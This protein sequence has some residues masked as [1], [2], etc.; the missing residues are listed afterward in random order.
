MSHGGVKDF[1]LISKV[2]TPW[3]R[4][5]TQLTP[6]EMVKC[7]TLYFHWTGLGCPGIWLNIISESVW[8]GI[9]GLD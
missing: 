2:R 5:C 1:K 3:N 4:Q 7:I 9:S 8:D 6:S